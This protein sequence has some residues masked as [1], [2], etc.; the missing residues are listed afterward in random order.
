MKWTLAFGSSLNSFARSTIGEAD[1]FA[2][3]AVDHR[4]EQLAGPR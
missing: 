2:R 4:A 1:D 3:G